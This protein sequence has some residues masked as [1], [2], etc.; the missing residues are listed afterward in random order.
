MLKSKNFAILLL[1]PPFFS[2]AGN[3]FAADAKV[4]FDGAYGGLSLGYNQTSVSE[5]SANLYYDSATGALPGLFTAANG[6]SSKSNGIVGVLNFGYDHRIND[7]VIGAE[8]SGSLPSGTASGYA[9]RDDITDAALNQPISSTTKIQSIY[10]FKPKLGFVFNNN[11]MV[12]GMAGVALGSIKRTISDG[13]GGYWLDSSNSISSTKNQFGYTLGAGVE[14]VIG[15]Q[16]SVKFEFNYVDLGNP[17][18]TYSGGTYNGAPVP[19]T[20]TIKVTNMAT[21]IGL[22]YKF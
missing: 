2:G 5:G 22:S 9:G 20:Q 1:V 21:T 6:Q 7:F 14:K 13:S 12:Y 3:A 4:A 11:F 17:S 16:L 10:A 15:E 18:Y 8:F 19:I